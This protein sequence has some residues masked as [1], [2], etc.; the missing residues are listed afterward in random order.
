MHTVSV[1]TPHRCFGQDVALLTQ[2]VNLARLHAHLAAECL[3]GNRRSL[4]RRFCRRR[5]PYGGATG[6]R[7]AA[8]A[9]VHDSLS[10][11]DGAAT[12]LVSIFAPKNRPEFPPSSACGDASALGTRVCMTPNAWHLTP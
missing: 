7:D 5:S 1:A 4:G 10:V 8:V 12:I 2:D 6:R 9:D 11:R 3:A